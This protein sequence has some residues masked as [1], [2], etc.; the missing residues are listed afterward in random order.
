M[1]QTYSGGVKA[2]GELSAFW[3]LSSTERGP[4]SL[5]VI[6]DRLTSKTTSLS[7]AFLLSGNAVTRTRGVL[8]GGSVVERNP[9]SE[10]KAGPKVASAQSL[11]AAHRR[12]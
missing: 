2:P 8:L 7:R 1:T 6:S 10:T 3:D 11:S 9:S 12:L 4:L 5:S